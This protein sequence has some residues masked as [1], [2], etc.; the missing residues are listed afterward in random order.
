MRE[1][2]VKDFAKE[3]EGKLAEVVMEDEYG[4]GVRFEMSKARIEYYKNDDE[5]SFCTGNYNHGGKGSFAICNTESN[6]ECIAEEDGC[7][8]I[9]FTYAMSDVVVTRY[10]SLEELEEERKHRVMTDDK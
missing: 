1:I 4:R 7:Y 10:K 2:T 9:T 6:I 3:F 8:T 5:L